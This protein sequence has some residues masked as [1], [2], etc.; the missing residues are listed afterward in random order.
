[1]LKLLQEF[2]ELLNGTLDDWDCKLVLLQLKES[3]QTCHGRPFPIPKKHVEILKKKL[4]RQCDL[5]VLKWQADSE[6]A[7]PNFIIP[8][9]ATLYGMLAILGKL[10]NR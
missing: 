7:L 6:W 9:K 5:G 2:E 10:T 3:A 8:K 1:M 4:Q